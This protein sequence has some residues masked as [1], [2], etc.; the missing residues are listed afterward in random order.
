MAKDGNSIILLVNIA[1]KGE[2]P[3]YE[4]VGE[5]RGLSI[6]TTTGA[7]DASHKLSD[8][9]K[10]LYG[11]AESTLTLDALFVPDD[12]GVKAIERAQFNKEPILVRRQQD[13]VAVEQA[14]GIITSVS[15]DWPDN[16]VST[17]SVEVALN[18]YP[19]ELISPDD[20]DNM[21]GWYKADSLSLSDGG[22]V[23]TWS[24][25]SSAS[26]DLSATTGNEPTYHED[27]L[28]GYPVVRFDPS[29]SIQYLTTS[30]YSSALTQPTSMFIVW[31][32]T[33]TKSTRSEQVV[34]T[35]QSAGSTQKVS[36]RTDDR[37][38]MTAGDGGNERLTYPHDVPFSEFILTSA[39]FNQTQGEFW[40]NGE[41]IRRGNIGTNDLDGLTV[42]A[43][44]GGSAGGFYGDI[45]EIIIFSDLLT[46][47]ER[48][49][50][51]VYLANK[52]ALNLK[53]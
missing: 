43:A 7:I 9:M 23:T 3:D 49:G 13:G 52:Y 34:V 37:L 10:N 28:N 21:E 6:D 39:L 12:L 30:A 50:I 8:H 2:A 46:K 27:I 15:Y 32:L 5:Q 24:D 26:S 47:Q 38:L 18:Q 4:A 41:L 53:V 29:S 20:L 16:D 42:G 40:E 17:I 51:E 1:E 25:S 36:V 31:K 14:E 33:N 45:A 35:G 22:T 11:R 44:S 48:A 19:V